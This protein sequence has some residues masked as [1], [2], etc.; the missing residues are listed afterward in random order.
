MLKLECPNCRSCFTIREWNASPHRGGESIPEDTGTD[1]QFQQWL[2]E[3]NG[4][5]YDCPD[6]GEPAVSDDMMAV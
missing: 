6:C 4:T 2:T 3:R 1:E 5:I